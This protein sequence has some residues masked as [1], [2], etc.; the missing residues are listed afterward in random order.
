MITNLIF[1]A[2]SIVA[3]YLTARLGGG[4]PQPSRI[5][6]QASRPDDRRRS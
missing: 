2:A 1:F 6:V 4:Q 5:P 3:A